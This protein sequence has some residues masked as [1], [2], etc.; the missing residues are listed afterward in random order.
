MKVVEGFGRQSDRVVTERGGIN[1]LAVLFGGPVRTGVVLNTI[2]QVR[3][4]GRHQ[5]AALARKVSRRMGAQGAEA[6]LKSQ[7]VAQ[8]A[9]AGP[10]KVGVAMYR[11]GKKRP[12]RAVHRGWRLGQRNQRGD[13]GKARCRWS[14]PARVRAEGWRGRA[15]IDG[16]PEWLRRV[17]STRS[18]SSLGTGP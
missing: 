11:N 4:P 2:L 17:G 6:E 3:H 1:R 8:G 14:G 18:C 10:N 15:V 16:D 5:K 12:K 13:A 7:E 9:K